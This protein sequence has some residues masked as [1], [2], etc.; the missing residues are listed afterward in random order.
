MRGFLAS[1]T[2]ILPPAAALLDQLQLAYVLLD[3]QGLITEVN[4]TL[5]TLTGYSRTEVIGQSYHEL[6]SPISHR[7]QRQQ[8]LLHVLR[9]QA[10]DPYYDHDLLARDGQ[11]VQ[12]LGAVVGVHDVGQRPAG[13]LAGLVP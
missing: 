13:E 11:L 9:E 5:L 8:E 2:P 1:P 12:Q 7:E 10:P 4:E 3:R 6:F